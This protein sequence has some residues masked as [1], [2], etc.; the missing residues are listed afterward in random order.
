MANFVA[1]AAV[2]LGG[3]QE[4]KAQRQS[5]KRNKISAR[6]AA[7]T[8]AKSRRQSVAKTRRLRAQTVAQAE[9]Q[10]VTGGSSATQAVGSIQSQGNANLNF[11]RQ[12]ESLDQQRFSTEQK[13]NSARSNASS[14][15]AIAGVANSFAD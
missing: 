2:V 11:S 1:I 7:L 8:N 5:K 15:Q 10:G 9:A 13:I 3:V 12:L 14:F 4:N 6:A